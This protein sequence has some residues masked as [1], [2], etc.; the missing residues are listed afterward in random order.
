MINI[1]IADLPIAIDNRYPYTEE[2]CLSYR[3]ERPPLFTVRA[4]DAAIAEEREISG[5]TA[6]PY[7]E[8]TVVYREIARRLPQYDA[9]VFHGAVIALGGRAYAFTARSGT[10]KTT[11]LRLWLSEFGEEVHILNGDKPILRCMDGVW[12]AAGTPWRGKEKYGVNEILPLAGIVFLERG[13]ENRIS[14]LAAQEAFPQM[15]GQCFWPEDEAQ[16]DRAL[17]LTESVLESVPLYR[18][19]CNMAPEAAH[20]ARAG[21][22][23]THAAEK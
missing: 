5:I 14:P 8:S 6:P 16:L 1:S 19:A 4:S 17:S 22:E 20:V 18:L 9:M 12:C 23:A 11:H 21:I 3:T 10:G 2:L 7:L 15:Y 13:Q